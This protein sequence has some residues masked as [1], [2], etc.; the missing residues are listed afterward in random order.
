MRISNYQG[1][2][3]KMTDAELAD[4][5][6]RQEEARRVDDLARA[7]FEGAPR[8]VVERHD[9]EP[10]E[11]LAL[12][13]TRIT[14]TTRACFPP[15]DALFSDSVRG[16]AMG[17]AVQPRFEEVDR[18]V[19]LACGLSVHEQIPQKVRITPLGSPSVLTE[20]EGA[21]L[22]VPRSGGTLALG[23]FGGLGQ[24][25][26][27]RDGTLFLVPGKQGASES[28]DRRLHG[29]MP[30]VLQRMSFHDYAEFE[31]RRW[32]NDFSRFLHDAYVVHPDGT[33]QGFEFHEVPGRF[34]SETMREEG[35]RVEVRQVGGHLDPDGSVVI[36]REQ[37]SDR[38]TRVTPWITQQQLFS[39]AGVPDDLKAYYSETGT[40]EVVVQPAPDFPGPKP[41]QVLEAPRF[42]QVGPIRVRKKGG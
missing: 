33:V 5:R 1:G 17:Y 15:A 35:G 6:L 21:Y 24:E 42:V 38:P 29:P 7:L 41:S 28:R 30:A 20:I 3:R 4:W 27:V 19:D 12:G 8:E 22:Q 25:V 31:L 2:G 14:R 40:R 16:K 37:P 13:F 36:E 39:Q 10:S 18:R 32:P 9:V 34:N 23:P 26:D 11:G